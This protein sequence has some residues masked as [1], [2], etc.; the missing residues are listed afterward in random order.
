[1][2]KKKPEIGKICIWKDMQYL[3][4]G[5]KLNHTTFNNHENWN[6]DHPLYKCLGCDGYDYNC[7]G[8]RP[9]EEI[10][11]KRYK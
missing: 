4:N 7:N 2:V 5:G 3:H 1:M 8:Y 10:N 9:L 11:R 6:P